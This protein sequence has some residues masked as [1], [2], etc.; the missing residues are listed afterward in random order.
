V[1]PRQVPTGLIVPVLLIGATVGRLVGLLTVLLL[2]SP[3]ADQ[4]CDVFPEGTAEREH[5]TMGLNWVDPGAFAIYGSAA[6]FG[7]ISVHGCPPNTGLTCVPCDRN[8]HGPTE[9]RTIHTCPAMCG[10]MLCSAST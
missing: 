4:D 1:W 8:A 10:L 7:G 6:F 2:G 3:T 9:H 5:C